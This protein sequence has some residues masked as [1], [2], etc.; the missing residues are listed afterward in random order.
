[1]QIICEVNLSHLLNDL[2]PENGEG[3]F[4]FQHFIDLS[5]TYLLTPTHLFTA[6]GPTW[7]APTTRKCNG[8]SAPLSW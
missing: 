6:P 8:Q 3:L 1:M 7:G 2:Q 4:L 5:L